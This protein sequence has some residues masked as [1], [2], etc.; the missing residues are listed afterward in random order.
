VHPQKIDFLSGAGK[1]SIHPPSISF[2]LSG[3]L[4]NPKAQTTISH[5]NL[6]KMQL[7]KIWFMFS[8]EE[9]KWH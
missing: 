2:A 8:S 6:A 4:T 3:G 7:N 5:T 1:E 9:Q